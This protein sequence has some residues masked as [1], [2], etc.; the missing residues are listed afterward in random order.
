MLSGWVAIVHA[1]GTVNVPNPLGVS[2]FEPVLER[3]ADGMFTVAIPLVGIMGLYGGFQIITAAGNEEKFS[4]GRKTLLYAAI[5]FIVVMLASS[6]VRII[7][8]LLT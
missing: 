5:G 1:Q 7:V 2:K 6:I 4:A 3:I 8:S